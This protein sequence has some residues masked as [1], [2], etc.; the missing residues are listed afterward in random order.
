M[1]GEGEP[2]GASVGSA[3]R[4]RSVRAGRHAA[5][6]VIYASAAV[7]GTAIGP[8][9]IDVSQV[10]VSLAM[11][12]V[13]VAIAGT[14]WAFAVGGEDTVKRF[15]TLTE[16]TP[17]GRLLIPIGTVPC[18]FPG[19]AE[20]PTDAGSP[21]GPSRSIL[22]IRIPSLWAVPRRSVPGLLGWA[23][24]PNVRVGLSFVDTKRVNFGDRCRIGHLHVVRQTTELQTAR[25]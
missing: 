17:T 19:S 15:R 23:V 25:G 3:G 18:A 16:A 4:T 13:G 21:V 6:E 14:G 20:L 1:L 12:L 22:Q 10:R 11:A 24:G 9:I 5:A 8:F 7:A 2:W